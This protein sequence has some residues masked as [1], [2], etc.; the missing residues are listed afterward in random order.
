MHSAAEQRP[1]AVSHNL[2]KKTA[3]QSR[4]LRYPPPWSRAPTSELS[5][6]A[7]TPQRGAKV[8]ADTAGSIFGRPESNESSG[9]FLRTLDQQP[10]VRP[11]LA[12]T[13]AGDTIR[14]TLPQER[15]PTPHHFRNFAPGRC[16]IQSTPSPRLVPAVLRK[17]QAL[18]AKPR[19]AARRSF[20]PA[21]GRRCRAAAG[22][23]RHRRRKTQL[24]LYGSLHFPGHPGVHRFWPAGQ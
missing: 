1:A 6:G 11:G 9:W 18:P 17:L 12:E 19:A 8:R 16:G 13:P 7:Q 23:A 24:C 5:Q 21:V 20:L 22:T 4:R 14:K 10:A 3:G 2:G 15:K